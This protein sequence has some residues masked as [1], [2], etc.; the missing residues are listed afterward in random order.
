MPWVQRSAGVIVA[1]FARKQP[2]VAEEFVT[3]LKFSISADMPG[4][5]VNINKLENEIAAS[6]IT[7]NLF[8]VRANGDVLN[9]LFDTLP[10]PAGDKTIL[11]NDQVGPA[12]GL[13][14][15]HD[16]TKVR[17]VS[18]LTTIP[19]RI[20]RPKQIGLGI[21]PDA[22]AI[23][24]LPSTTKGLLPPRMT[25]AQRNAI[26]SPAEGL[27]VFD[28]TAK[29]LYLFKNGAWCRLP[30]G[31]VTGQFSDS[32]TQLPVVTT[33]VPITFNTNDIV[34]E[35]ISHSET[36]N[37]EEFTAD[38][39]KPFTFQLAPQWTADGAGETIDFFVQLNTGSGFVNV[40]NSNIK[41][42]T[43]AKGSAVSFLGVPINMNVGDKV[44]FMQR[45][46]DPGALLGI[47]FTAAEVGPPAIPATPSAILQ[48]FSGD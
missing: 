28:T 36:V 19:G 35:G 9:F 27:V 14:A 10:L 38:I 12:G 39:A 24:D 43:P 31:I 18:V 44:R 6:A 11:S 13:L 3:P 17:I 16:N 8:R 34:L 42:E 21:K 25:T 47:E 1:A 26:S 5:A 48:V 20:T 30:C 41:I 45:V 15:A 33:P 32:I 46:S 23:L 29:G 37:P 22:S 4:G 40:A 2:G 7:T